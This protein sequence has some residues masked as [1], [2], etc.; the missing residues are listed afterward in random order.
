MTHE[1]FD[2]KELRNVAKLNYQPDSKPAQLPAS[3]QSDYQQDSR[4]L[5]PYFQTFSAVRTAP[6]K[7]FK[8][9]FLFTSS[10]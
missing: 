9:N 4:L 2:A 10:M 3:F 1:N 6:L 5:H 7:L 8:S